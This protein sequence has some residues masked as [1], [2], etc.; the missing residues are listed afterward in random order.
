MINFA[1]IKSFCD[2]QAVIESYGLVVEKNG[3]MICPFHD[4]RTPSMK[5][6][7]DH[8]HCF[9]CQAHGDVIDF[10][11]RL[12]GISLKEAAEKIEKDFG[13]AEVHSTAKP[14]IKTK[15]TVI[16]EKQREQEAFRILCDY[17]HL[18]R[19]AR[20]EFA[21]KSPDEPFHPLF[22]ESL[23]CLNEYEYYCDI[24][25]SGSKEE[26]TEFMDSR[27]ELLDS[28]IQK[29]TAENQLEPAILMA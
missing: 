22:A 9:G 19:A 23:Q 2:L 12:F 29:L 15:L 16:G 25:I 6:Y 24:F 14:S 18:L 4:D 1:G 27:K 26:R 10:I 5:I 17:C 3:M 20:T 13:I 21:P 7:D 8:F 28:L 11:S